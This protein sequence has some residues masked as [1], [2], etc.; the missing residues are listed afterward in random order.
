MK[1][2]LLTVVLIL[3]GLFVAVNESHACPPEPPTA[4]LDVTPSPQFAG[5]TLTVDGN[6]YY[7]DANIVKYEFDFDGDGDYDYTE[8]DSNYP[9]GE[10]DG[11]TTW[12]YNEPSEYAVKLQVTD[13][14]QL[15][16]IDTMVVSY[17]T[18]PGDAE[19]IQE[20]INEAEDGLIIVVEPG[21]YEENLDFTDKEITLTSIDPDDPEVV[22]ATIIDGGDA[23]NVIVFDLGDANSTI[24]GFTITNGNAYYGG[25]IF[26][27]NYRK[28]G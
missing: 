25:G 26:C 22:A 23:N 2:K 10:F 14:Q 9:D 28:C 8:T 21:T 17:F 27:G 20:A 11:I 6:D 16:D 5:C 1:A 3:I 12:T 4:V 19:T 7:P 18:V 13:N 15:A 24:T